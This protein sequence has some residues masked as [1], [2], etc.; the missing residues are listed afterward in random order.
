MSIDQDD[1]TDTD[2]TENFTPAML[3]PLAVAIAF[4]N[5]FA[6]GS[7]AYKLVTTDKAKTAALRAADKADRRAADA[8][9]KF[10]AITAQAEQVQAA[11]DAR[12]AELDR[13]EA[14][15]ARRE[16]ELA[17]SAQNVRDELRSYHN[18]LDE[19]HRQL[20]HRVM[21]CSGILSGW[22]PALQALPTWA[23]LRRQIADLPDDMPASA[24][25]PVLP[26]DALS[27]TFADPNA[28]RHG[29]AFLGSLSRSIEHKRG[30]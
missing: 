16:D 13:R 1:E 9:Q 19:T 25:A 21:S 30:A 8:A 3:D 15:I 22:N 7:K 27:D 12:A 24:V 6:E 11:L 17:A 20:I 29:Q 18:H 28:D 26:I 10:A 23:Q 14:E 2:D 5:F 4:N